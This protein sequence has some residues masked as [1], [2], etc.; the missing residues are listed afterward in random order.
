MTR[1][2]FRELSWGRGNLVSAKGRALADAL[3]ASANASLF[4][5]STEG[6]RRARPS[7]LSEDLAA[8]AFLETQAV[9]LVFK[10]SG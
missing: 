1:G 6:L 5:P 2:G 9:D 4:L 10:L 8:V 3:R 7:D